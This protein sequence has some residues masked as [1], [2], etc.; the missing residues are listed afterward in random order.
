MNPLN[1]HTCEYA[2]VRLYVGKWVY[3]LIYHYVFLF[4][5]SSCANCLLLCNG[6]LLFFNCIFRQHLKRGL[7]YL[8]LFSLPSSFYI[9]STTTN[10]LHILYLHNR[11]LI[12]LFYRQN[13][14]NH[15]TNILNGMYSYHRIFLIF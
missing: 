13:K 14:S 11:V 12:W 9:H 15:C 7:L 6:N 8:L 3:A 2:W 4:I 10:P 5:Y 1:V